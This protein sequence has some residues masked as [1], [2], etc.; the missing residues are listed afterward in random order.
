M[1][2]DLRVRE[3][4]NHPA[5]TSLTLGIPPRGVTPKRKNEP[6]KLFR[7][8]KSLEKRT[9]DEPEESA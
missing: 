1:L 4:G 2:R 9:R 5:I 7:I 6:E 8:S 3:E